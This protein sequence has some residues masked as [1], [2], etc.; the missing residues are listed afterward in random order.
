M[1]YLVFKSKPIFVLKPYYCFCTSQRNDVYMYILPISFISVRRHK[2]T[3]GVHCITALHPALGFD[4]VSKAVFRHYRQVGT[5]MII[6]I[7]VI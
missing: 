6:M 4:A 1:F 2:V 3:R 5:N 7:M